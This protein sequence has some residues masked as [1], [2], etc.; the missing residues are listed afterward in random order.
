MLPCQLGSWRLLRRVGPL[1]H[2]E[3]EAGERRT[4]CLWQAGSDG[5]VFSQVA[6]ALLKPRHSALLRVVAH[7]RMEQ[8]YALTL[9]TIEEPQALRAVLAEREDTG[10]WLLDR[11]EELLLAMEAEPP[12]FR[13]QPLMADGIVISC[14]GQ[15]RL[16]PRQPEAEADPAEK[17]LRDQTQL[18]ALLQQLMAQQRVTPP[19]ASRPWMAKLAAGEF[20][21]YKQARQE[22][23]AQRKGW[24]RNTWP[25]YVN[26]ASRA[27]FSLVGVLGKGGMGV[28]FRA[29]DDDD[30]EYAIKFLHFSNEDTEAAR[31]TARER[32]KLEADKLAQL[33]GHASIVRFVSYREQLVDGQTC[34]MIV[35]GLLHGLRRPDLVFLE[36][37]DPQWLMGFLSEVL[38]AV[39][40]MHRENIVHRDLKP[41]NLAAIYDEKDHRWRAVVMDLGLAKAEHDPN[42]TRSGVVG[43]VLYLAPE[44]VT[45]ARLDRRTDLFQLGVILMQILA[46]RH[47]MQ[48]RE[49]ETLP[50][51]MSS[52][53]LIGAIRS[54]Q[55]VTRCA[56]PELM[57][58]AEK[59]TAKMVEARPPTAQAAREM[60]DRMRQR[61]PQQPVI[62]FAASRVGQHDVWAN[63]T[64]AWTERTRCLCL[65]GSPGSGKTW[66]LREF[67][68]WVLVNED[69][70]VHWVKSLAELAQKL[71]CEATPAALS[72]AL[73]NAAERTSRLVVLEREDEL[74]AEDVELL[75]RLKNGARGHFLLIA[76]A[77]RTA[78]PAG[79]DTLKLQDLTR[80]ECGEVV[81]AL[82]AADGVDPF[83]LDHL[84]RTVGSNPGFITAVLAKLRSGLHYVRQDG[85][86]MEG[87]EAEWPVP[88]R[89]RQGLAWLL[90]SLPEGQQKLLAVAGTLG[91]R[92]DE[93]ILAEVLTPGADVQQALSEIAR[94]VSTSGSGRWFLRPALLAEVARARSTDARDIHLRAVRALQQHSASRDRERQVAYHLREA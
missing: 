28:V 3:S 6:D 9:D 70:L 4:M 63:L 30:D 71:D 48:G 16:A 14:R 29:L 32:F 23:Q 25:L 79:V 26:A 62:S 1:Y 82:L 12:G 66:I 65:Q 51:M 59:L 57:A 81:K 58:L 94:Y 54:A 35:T 5:A 75:E 74:A 21:S 31:S 91:A 52:G 37:Q 15:A 88:D 76:A 10:D 46:G 92:F 87:P 85:V 19:E 86:I 64:A 49:Q 72:A 90:D 89:V 11:A 41:S 38:Q 7:E 13:Y 78:A 2:A 27:G 73:Q 84:V 33:R 80:D 42:L 18:S 68:G 61:L 43:T 44:Q 93:G 77:R 47:P 83:F 50:V 55:L 67:V 34:P 39:E 17:L 20:S 56:Y 60:L 8:T 45:G 22:L 36:K 40:A 24:L 69:T 53:G